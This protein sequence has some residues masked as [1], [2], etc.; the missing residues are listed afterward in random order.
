MHFL[1]HLYKI[2]LE[3]NADIVSLPMFR[4]EWK[5]I[6][7]ENGKFFANKIYYNKLKNIR[8]NF[9]GQT[10]CSRLIKKDIA[11]AVC[12]DFYNESASNIILWEDAIFS[13]GIVLKASSIYEST[14]NLYCYVKNE[15]S[16]TNNTQLDLFESFNQSID[17]YNLL[18]QEINKYQPSVKRYQI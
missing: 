9:E 12:E 11:K 18:S 17:L 15:N 1:E 4:K 13:Y 8:A 10:C 6:D 5:R 2:E 14:R 3:T 7:S 16:I